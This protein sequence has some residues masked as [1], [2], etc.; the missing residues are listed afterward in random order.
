MRTMTVRVDDDRKAAA[1]ETLLKDMPHVTVSEGEM[2]LASLW[3]VG[4]IE[5]LSK[6]AEDFDKRNP[7]CLCRIEEDGTWTPLKVIT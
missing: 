1:L 5:Y 6:E 4:P 3:E 7:P 2:E